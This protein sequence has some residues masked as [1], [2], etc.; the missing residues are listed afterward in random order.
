MRCC[1]SDRGDGGGY[2][3]SVSDDKG[4][5]VSVTLENQWKYA[6]LVNIIREI[7]Y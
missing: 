4:M 5:D 7:K 2:E 6:K 1:V 3:I